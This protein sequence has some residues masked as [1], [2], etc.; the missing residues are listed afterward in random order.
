MDDD[1]EPVEQD[2]QSFLLLAVVLE[3]GLGVVALVLGGLF[4]PDPRDVVPLVGEIWQLVSGLGWGILASLPLL[5]GVQLLERLPIEPIRRLQK[6]T[7]ERLVAL[8]AQFSVP[9]LGLISLCAGV[10]EE[11]LFRGWLMMS[12]AGPIQQWQTSTLVLAIVVSSI[13]FGLAHPITPGYV[14]V[15]GVIGVYMAMLLVWTGNLLVP[16][17]AHAFYDFVQLVVIT[18]GATDAGGVTDP[19]SRR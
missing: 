19:E 14:M 8:M 12:I 16:I 10:G 7:E 15:T 17:M 6:E 1:N 18:R 3:L 5:V 2:P 11:M 13:A 9:E 4:G